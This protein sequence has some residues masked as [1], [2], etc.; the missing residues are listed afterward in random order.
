[1]TKSPGKIFLIMSFVEII[2]LSKLCKTELKLFLS[3]IAYAISSEMLD[4][5]VFYFLLRLL[6][7]T[8]NTEKRGNLAKLKHL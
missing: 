1:M 6:K 2:L 8:V 3:A 7:L 5:R 4:E